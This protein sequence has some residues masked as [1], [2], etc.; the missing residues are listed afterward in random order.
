M[1]NYPKESYNIIRCMMTVHHELGCG[2]LE[3]VKF[4]IIKFSDAKN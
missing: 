4:E 1:I 2:F 3:L